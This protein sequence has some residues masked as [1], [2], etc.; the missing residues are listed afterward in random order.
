MPKK[1]QVGIVPGNHNPDNNYIITH[2]DDTST[3]DNLIN[4]TL[5]AL[6]KYKAIE[7]EFTIINDLKSVHSNEDI[8]DVENDIKKND[9]FKSNNPLSENIN[10][11]INRMKSYTNMKDYF[12][13]NSELVAIESALEAQRDALTYNIKKAISTIEKSYGNDITKIDSLSSTF[14][15][16]ALN[17]LSVIK[18]KKIETDSLPNYQY[19]K[20]S[21]KPKSNFELRKKTTQIDN[22]LKQAVKFK[23]TGLKSGYR[24]N[25]VKIYTKKIIDDL[26]DKLS[27]N[28]DFLHPI[29]E[30]RN[31][32]TSITPKKNFD[33]T[34]E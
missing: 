11:C 3:P 30:N 9:L 20:N 15:K 25:D 32:N 29:E 1:N 14:T 5:D 16:K 27:A 24:T 19:V 10:N 22:S 7:S 12:S 28:N 13:E 23:F 6:Q 4:Y 8:L 21:D 18:E 17:E 26:K 31:K 34:N 33:R 2:T